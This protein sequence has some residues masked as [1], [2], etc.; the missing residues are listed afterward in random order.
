MFLEIEDG[1]KMEIKC[2]GIVNEAKCQFT[3]K[4]VDFGNIPVGLKAKDQTVHI[5]NQMRS[6]AVFH[7][8]PT[9]EELTISPMRGKI[10]PDQK[11][12]FTVGFIS[13]VPIDFEEEI[14]VN[15]RGGKSLKLPVRVRAKIPE[16]DIEEPEID[17][18]GITLGDSKT[19]PM[20]IYN[21]SDIP[22]KLILD[23]RDFPEFELIVPPQEFVDDAGSELMVPIHDEPN[24]KDIE[25]MNPEDINDPLNE[26]DMDEDD[27]EDEE[28]QNRY[29][30]LSLKP[31]TSPLRLQFK[32]TPADVEDPRDFILPIKLAG[33]GNMECL[34]RNFKGVGV[35][36]RFLLEPTIVNFRTKVIAKGSKPLP[37]HN[38]VTI[39]NPN[40]SPINWSID[41]NVLDDSKVF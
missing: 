29:V 14:T 41:R 7:V 40:N 23:I 3:D 26:E 31:E 1:K 34:D 15:I 6:T 4:M 18:G 22:A 19:L 8:E 21:R 9:S 25:N 16:I 2:Q 35:K 30:Q 33:V 39:T 10:L 37:F 32:Y 38:D 28:E 27:D 36:P 17:F 20:T 5:K 12:S 11:L 13:H 24:Y